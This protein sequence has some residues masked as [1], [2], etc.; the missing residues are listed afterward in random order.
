MSSF[1]FY[2]FFFLPVF[3]TLFLSVVFLALFFLAGTILT[4]FLP[5]KKAQGL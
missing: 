3:L 1:T 2:F 4:P 5:T